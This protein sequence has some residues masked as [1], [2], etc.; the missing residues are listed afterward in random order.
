MTNAARLF[1]ERVQEFQRGP[2]LTACVAIPTVI[3]IAAGFVAQRG[4]EVTRSPDRLKSG[5]D[6]RALNK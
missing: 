1:D 4:G 6:G 2:S 3:L 5:R